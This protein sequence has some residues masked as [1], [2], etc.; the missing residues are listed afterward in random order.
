MSYLIDF[1]LTGLWSFTIISI[2]TSTYKILTKDNMLF[3]SLRFNNDKQ[4]VILRGVPGSG[5]DN[6]IYNEEKNKNR[7]FINIS[8]D[9]F[10]YKLTEK[11]NIYDFNRKDLNEIQQKCLRDFLIAI[12]LNVPII[13]LNDTYQQKWMYDNYIRLATYFKYKVQIVNFDCEDKN[14]LKYFNYRSI[15]NVPM[16]FSEKVY[17]EYE[18]DERTSIRINSEHS[19]EMTE[20]TKEMLDKDIDDFMNNSNGFEHPYDSRSDKSY[21]SRSDKSY[22]SRS[23]KSY[24]SRSDKRYDS[25]YDRRYDKRYDR[26]YDK[27]YDKRYD[28][29]YDSR[30]DSRYEYESSSDSSSESS[31]D[32][33]SESSY[34]STN[35]TPKYQY[36]NKEL[37]EKNTNKSK[38][39]IKENFELNFNSGKSEEVSNKIH[40]ILNNIIQYM[41]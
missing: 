8:K 17:N 12:K 35:P 37:I 23:D 27:R 7:Y 1:A 33:S 32:S 9:K 15:H 18:Y 13:Y 24:D 6:F 3:K 16:S 38:N 19:K 31:S 22:D 4:L 10:F 29:R 34:E 11:G 20:L 21:D 26:R 36:N 30:Y 25:R 14:V 41:F 28:R 39:L 40:I 2:V 5:K